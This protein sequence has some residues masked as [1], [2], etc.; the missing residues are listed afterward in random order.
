[1]TPREPPPPLPRPARGRLMIDG[2]PPGKMY[3]REL[4]VRCPPGVG[5]GARIVVRSPDGRATEV[6]VPSGVAPGGTFVVDLPPTSPQLE[7]RNS[8]L[9]FCGIEWWAPR[10]QGSPLAPCR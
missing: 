4:E 8:L 1:M 2:P 7:V 6:A 10:R 9:L 3:P 5:G